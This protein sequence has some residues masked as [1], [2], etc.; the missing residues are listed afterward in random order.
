MRR[1]QG[2]AIDMM[3]T[4][5]IYVC[6]AALAVTALAQSSTLGP[7]SSSTNYSVD[8]LGPV[9]TRPNCW[10]NADSFTWRMPFHP[11]VGYRVRILALHGDLVAWPKVLAGAPPVPNGAYAGVLVGIST[12][13]P[14]GSANCDFC[15]DPTMLY[16]QGG[17]NSGSAVRL[18]YD[19]TDLSAVLEPDNNL[20]IKV[21][22]WLNTT[23]YP[24]HIEP[25]FTVRYQFEREP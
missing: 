8:L 5:R 23:G 21:A 10:G 13:A 6:W 18:P 15:D 4:L 25:T 2:R 22:S 20:L 24:I 3:R 16:L 14:S 7:Y 9:D 19:R 1:T 12:S 11:P 17:I